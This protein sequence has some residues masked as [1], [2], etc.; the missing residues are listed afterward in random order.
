MKKRKSRKN[1][2]IQNNVLDTQEYL[3]NIKSKIKL[4]KYILNVKIKF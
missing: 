4:L 1:K 3:K 2:L